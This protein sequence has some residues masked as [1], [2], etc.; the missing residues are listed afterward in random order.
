MYVHQGQNNKMNILKLTT[1]GA[2]AA[3][4]V[5]AQ[6]SVQ[7]Q[8]VHTQY[9]NGIATEVDDSV[10]NISSGQTNIGSYGSNIITHTF[11]FSVGDITDESQM[12]QSAK[13]YFSDKF[14]ASDVGAVYMNNSPDG[15]P[16]KVGA[17]TDPTRSD[18]WAPPGGTGSIFLD[19]A[20]SQGWSPGDDELPG[21]DIFSTGESLGI[22]IIQ[23]D[24]SDLF[25]GSEI[26]GMEVEI[27]N[28]DTGEVTMYLA[29]DTSFG[30]A[31]SGNNQML[32]EPSSMLLISMAVLPVIFRRKRC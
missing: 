6:A 29:G 26:T 8:N 21:D 17:Y 23:Y 15:P 25:N 7:I 16:P 3:A 31:F 2:L 18:V 14:N 20:A 32:P 27:Y 1:V 30:S 11:N 10:L 12:V 9:V 19:F 13:I 4:S 28:Q 24:S 5:D 22:S